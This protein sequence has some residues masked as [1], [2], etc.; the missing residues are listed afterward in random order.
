M[1]DFLARGLERGGCGDGGSTNL[2]KLSEFFFF[3]LQ[4]TFLDHVDTQLV[5][6]Q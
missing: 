4:C 2:Y 3:C 1:L 5:R 6:L